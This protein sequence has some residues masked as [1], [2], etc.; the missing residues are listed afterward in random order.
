MSEGALGLS[1]GLEYEIGSYSD[2]SEVVAMAAVAA[3]HGGVYETHT[4]D[5]GNKSF[6]ALNEEIA[7][8]DRAQIPV[9]HSHIKVSTTSVWGQAPEMIRVIDAARKRGVDFLADCYPYDAWH[10]NLKVIMPEAI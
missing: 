8:A 2:T 10:S 7:I 4:R 1:S 9:E 5:E 6:S 3:K